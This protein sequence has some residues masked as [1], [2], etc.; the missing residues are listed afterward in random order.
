M[1]VQ[2]VINSTTIHTCRRKLRWRTAESGRNPASIGASKLGTWNAIFAKKGGNRWP[3][4]ITPGKVSGRPV[5]PKASSGPVQDCH[6]SSS[7]KD[8]QQGLGRNTIAEGPN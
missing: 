3:G 6:K 4:P 2:R 7:G 8:C 1:I 5:A